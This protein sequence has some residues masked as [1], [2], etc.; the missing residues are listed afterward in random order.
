MPYDDR[1]RMAKKFQASQVLARISSY[2][3]RR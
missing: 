2:R 1:E 3:R